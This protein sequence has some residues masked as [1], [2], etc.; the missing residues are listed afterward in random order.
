MISHLIHHPS[1][2]L[3]RDTSRLMPHADGRARPRP[4]V[5]SVVESV[6]LCLSP[7]GFDVEFIQFLQGKALEAAGESQLLPW[8]VPPPPPS[9]PTV[10]GRLDAHSQSRDWTLWPPDLLASGCENPAAFLAGQQGSFAWDF[11]SLWRY[12]CTKTCIAR[13]LQGPG[14][15]FG[16]LKL[17]EV[18]GNSGCQEPINA[19]DWETQIEIFPGLSQDT[20]V[21]R[22]RP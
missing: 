19:I 21:V 14:R 13:V 17:F 16:T 8:E 12:F 6:V 11:K 3:G 1:G 10:K 2:A 22:G 4:Q 20:L 18:S 7:P 5:S 9:L 15:T